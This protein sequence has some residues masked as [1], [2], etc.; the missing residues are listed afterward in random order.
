MKNEAIL[1]KPRP[2]SKEQSGKISYEG[3]TEEDR[4][5]DRLLKKIKI[6]IRSDQKRLKFG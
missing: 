2:N 5:Q 4:F 6:W 3:R 1:N